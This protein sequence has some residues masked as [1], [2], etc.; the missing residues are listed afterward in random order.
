MC[1]EGIAGCAVRSPPY[2]LGIA[3]CTDPAAL[4]LIV[5]VNGAL[6]Q[7][8]GSDG[9]VEIFRGPSIQMPSLRGH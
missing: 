4:E 1:A 9:I 6:A 7:I 5:T 8:Y 2:P 3:R